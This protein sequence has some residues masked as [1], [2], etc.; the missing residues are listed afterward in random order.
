ML[1]PALFVPRSQTASSALRRTRSRGRLSRESGK[2]KERIKM[3]METH[4]PRIL[5]GNH[6]V[7]VNVRSSSP[8][9]A[10]IRRLPGARGGGARRVHHDTSAI[11][12]EDV[13]PT[14]TDD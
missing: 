14:N 1:L 6:V 5:K 12:L 2:S 3:E 8:T 4:D 10:I 11:T 7:N 13:L 9:G